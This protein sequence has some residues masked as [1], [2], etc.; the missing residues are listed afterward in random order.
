M[1][2]KTLETVADLFYNDLYEKLIPHDTV[3]M[4][5]RHLNPKLQKQ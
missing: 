3:K 4:V 2:H 5:C 1:D